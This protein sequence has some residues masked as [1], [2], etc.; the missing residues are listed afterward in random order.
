LRKT[1]ERAHSG[2]LAGARLDSEHA[3]RPRRRAWRPALAELPRARAG[4]VPACMIS[5]SFFLILVSSLTTRMLA[6][7]RGALCGAATLSPRKRGAEAPAPAAAENNTNNDDA[8]APTP[9]SSRQQQAAPPLPPPSADGERILL[10][11][12]PSRDARWVAFALA[13]PRD[14]APRRAPFSFRGEQYN[15]IPDNDAAAAPTAAAPPPPLLVC[16]SADTTAAT[17]LAFCAAWLGLPSESLSVAGGELILS[18][19][20]PERTVA[21]ARLG[22][23]ATGDDDAATSCALR[24]A[25]PLPPPPVR[26]VFA[27]PWCA[28]CLSAATGAVWTCRGGGGDGDADDDESADDDDDADGGG[29]GGEGGRHRFCGACVRRYA[30]TALSAR[31]AAAL[32]CPVP[33]CQCTLKSDDLAALVDLAALR[34][35][36]ARATAEHAARLR[37]IADGAE[38]R[39]CLPCAPAAMRSP[40][41][42]RSCIVDH[43]RCVKP[44]LTRA[45]LLPRTQG[46]EL[47]SLLARGDA[48]G[49]PCCRVLIQKAGGCRHMQ[50][51]VC[52]CNFEWQ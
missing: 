26:R 49:C 25:P 39:A 50:C 8:S 24:R 19:A 33:G 52:G 28:I 34:A 45:R 36:L 37:A 4:S 32:R 47:A 20:V 2:R 35:R 7:L 48:C 13:P 15:I 6:T 42:V 27:L 17:L 29:G 18:E 9:A 23:A 31:S 44:S 14:A 51:S 30:A 10:G 43:R 1:R 41:R 16:A 3:A 40:P 5:L 38:V 46:P 22:G 11:P 12:P 21:D